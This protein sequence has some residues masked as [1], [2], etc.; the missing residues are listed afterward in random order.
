MTGRTHLLACP[1]AAH[2]EVA[3]LL[4]WAAASSEFT[5]LTRCIP[6]HMLAQ[7]I[8]T[9]QDYQYSSASTVQRP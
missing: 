5:D 4:K 9:Q 3:S 1:R 6:H 7:P 8:T 2:D